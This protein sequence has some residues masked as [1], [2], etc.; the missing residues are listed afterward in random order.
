MLQKLEIQC[1]M[2]DFSLSLVPIVERGYINLYG[3]DI[4]ESKL[5]MHFN[6]VRPIS[7]C[8]LRLPNN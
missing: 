4:T 7:N 5:R 3:H 6:E 2:R 8:Y 1:G